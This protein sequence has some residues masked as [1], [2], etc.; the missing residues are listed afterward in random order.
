MNGANGGKQ[1]LE[2]PALRRKQAGE[3]GSI[4]LPVGG[5]V[6]DQVRKAIAVFDAPPL[7]PIGDLQSF[8]DRGHRTAHPHA[9]EI[10]RSCI[11]A[12]GERHAVMVQLSLKGLTEAARLKMLFGDHHLQPGIREQRCGGEAADA[13]SDHRHVEIS[14]T[15][16]AA[17]RRSRPMIGFKRAH[18]PRQRHLHQEFRP[19]DRRHG[20]DNHD[21]G[22]DDAACVQGVSERQQQKEHSPERAEDHVDQHEHRALVGSR[23]RGAGKL[24]RPGPSRQ[25]RR[26]RK[27]GEPD[28]RQRHRVGDDD[29]AGEEHADRQRAEDHKRRDLQHL[30]IA[31]IKAPGADDQGDDKSGADGGRRHPAQDQKHEDRDR[32]QREFHGE[33]RLH[34]H[35]QRMAS[36]QDEFA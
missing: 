14:I 19:Q 13:G 33:E 25:H 21:A 34:A 6:D 36:I 11:E 12:I 8:Q 30:D 9:G 29:F 20:S 7:D 2:S 17:Q 15:L 35:P 10:M 27:H 1:R 3:F 28:E 4:S 24:G 32:Q 23:I 5:H 22:G 18:L 26:D 31:R 16:R